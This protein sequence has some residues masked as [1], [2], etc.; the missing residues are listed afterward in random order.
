[1]LLGEALAHAAQ[2]YCTDKNRSKVLD[3]ELVD[4]FARLLMRKV[5]EAE[6][7]VRLSDARTAYYEELCKDPDLYRTYVDNVSAVLLD[8]NYVSVVSEDS[9]LAIDKKSRD[10]TAKQI[11]LKLFGVSY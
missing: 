8:M 1:M 9:V 3:P 4:D 2:V 10:E 7:A 6:R 5:N 11:I